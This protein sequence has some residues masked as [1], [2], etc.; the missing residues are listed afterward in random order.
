[1][2]VGVVQF[3]EFFDQEVAFAFAAG[4]AGGFAAV[5]V[6]AGGAGDG[7]RCEAG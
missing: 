1:M 2:W 4:F 7:G 3:L 5:A 6:G